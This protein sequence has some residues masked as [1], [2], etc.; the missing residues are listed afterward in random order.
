MLTNGD[1]I[2]VGDIVYTWE[3][4]TA[5]W[6]TPDAAQPTTVTYQQELVTPAIRPVAPPT[7]LAAPEPPP[8]E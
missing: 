1:T 7:P 6:V 2:T 3:A 5:T 8:E 4:A